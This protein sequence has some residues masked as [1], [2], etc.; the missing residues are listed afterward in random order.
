MLSI[1]I[2]VY[3]FR[4]SNLVNDLHQQCETNGI[5]YE[6][7]CFDDGS[8]PVFKQ[9]NQSIQQLKNVY[10]KE[11]SKNLGRSKI[12]NALGKAAQF[13]YL[14]FMDCDS[15]VVRI[16]YIQT[17]LNQLEPSTLLYGG[18]IYN[19]N[20]PKKYEYHLHYF[21][22][23]IRE[24][25]PTEERKI[26]PYYSFMTNNFLIPKELFINIQFSENIEGYGH[27]D[28]LFGIE[29]KKRKVKILHLNNPLEHLGLESM[30]VFLQKQKIAIK[31]LY[32][33]NKKEPLLETKLLATYVGCKKWKI[34]AIVLTVLTLLKPFIDKQLAKKKP[35]LFFLDLYKLQYLLKIDKYGIEPLPS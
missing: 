6:I 26:M 10:Y 13:P 35:N 22:G 16:D 3:N 33:L 7:I 27:E 20:P 34:N 12:R 29:L 9:K 31:N 23:K 1:L 28:T 25:I 32:L 30:K 5:V 21:Y 11:L 2:P 8:T 15:K 17:Y 14:L 24:E 19:I 4:I 18:R